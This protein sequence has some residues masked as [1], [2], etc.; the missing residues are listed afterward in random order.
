MSILTLFLLAL[1]LS[2]DAFAVSISNGL[3]FRNVKGLT[4]VGMALSYGVFQALMP[5]IGYALGTTFSGLIESVDHWIAFI[6]LGVIG[7]KMV[8]EAVQELRSPE[9]DACPA[10]KTLTFR[11]L[12]V[13]SVATSIDALAVGISLAIMRVNLL[14]SV[15]FIGAVT[16]VCCL[17][18]GFIGKK[19]GG[20]LKQ[21]AEIFGGVIL[22][23]IGVKILLEHLLGV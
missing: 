18:G 19:L 7:G 3:C 10:A 12:M 14:L 4:L 13:Q 23:L 11:T 1:G 6:L 21:K 2:M 5:L 17:V 15:G 20:A 9:G 8:A 16:F 22:V